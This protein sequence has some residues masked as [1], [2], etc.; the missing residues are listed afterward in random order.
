MEFWRIIFGHAG[1]GRGGERRT[2]RTKKEEELLLLQSKHHRN[3]LPHRPRELS[4]LVFVVGEH[5]AEEEWG[6]LVPA[7]HRVGDLWEVPPPN[8]LTRLQDVEEPNK[9]VFLL[10]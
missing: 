9:S 6:I 8:V 7:R 4:Q 10:V 5:P 1:L 3:F 2:G